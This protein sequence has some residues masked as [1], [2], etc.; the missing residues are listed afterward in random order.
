MT[1]L[2][3]LASGIVETEFDGETGISTLASE[4]GRLYEILGR[5]NN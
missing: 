1:A 3:D 4:R 5:I 2:E